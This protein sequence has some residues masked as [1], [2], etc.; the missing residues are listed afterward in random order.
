[1]KQNECL[2]LEIAAQVNVVMLTAAPSAFFWG[3]NRVCSGRS[4]HVVVDDLLQPFSTLFQAFLQVVQNVF[5]YV[6]LLDMKTIC[7][8]YSNK[9]C[10]AW[11][12][13]MSDVFLPNYKVGFRFPSLWLHKTITLNTSSWPLFWYPQQLLLDNCVYTTLQWLLH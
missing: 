13:F 10:S 5:S 8:Y 3:Q 1:M 7:V 2:C 9:M 4:Y 12:Q 6:F 11:L